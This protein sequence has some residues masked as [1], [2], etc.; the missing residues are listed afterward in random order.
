M[1]SQGIPSSST[2]N[3]RPKVIVDRKIKD[4]S[5]RVKT[6]KATIP[7]TQLGSCNHQDIVYTQSVKGVPQNIF[8]NGAKFSATL[9][10]KAFYKLESLS[11]KVNLRITGTPGA[12]VRLTMPTYFFDRV[13]FRAQNGAKHLNILYNDNMHFALA[14]LDPVV[15]EHAAR[16]MGI[17]ITN[18]TLDTAPGVTLDGSGNGDLELFIPFLGSWVDTGDLWWKGIDGDLVIDFYPNTNIRGVQTDTYGITCQSMDFVIQ[19]EALEDTDVQVQEK[20][21]SSVASETRFLDVTPINFFN[22]NI[23]QSATKRFELDALNG[24]VAFLVVYIRALN[25]DAS[26]N[27]RTQLR[28]IGAT[29]RVDI[30]D[31]GSKSILGSGNGISLNYLKHVILPHHFPNRFLDNHEILVIPFG[32]NSREAFG[33]ALDGCMSF[34]GSR[35]YLSITPDASFTTGNYNVTIYAYGYKTLVNAFGRLTITD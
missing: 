11:L 23:T 32:G 21:H 29:G 1:S 14:A 9:E 24:D 17:T 28:S 12:T 15:F 19:T 30:L 3:R 10:Q 35:Y 33:G 4:Q 31:P 18:N 16:A 6:T 34:D 27:H 22:E 13:E 25:G 20:F 8:T 5:G 26:S 2:L 7:T